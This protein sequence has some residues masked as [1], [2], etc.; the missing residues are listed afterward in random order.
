MKNL[1]KNIRDGVSFQSNISQSD[2]MIIFQKI[3]KYV[4]G[5]QNYTFSQ[6][7]CYINCTSR[8]YEKFHLFYNTEL[9]KIYYF[10]CRIT[11][12]K[13]VVKQSS[14]NEYVI[15]TLHSDFEQ[16]LLSELNGK[17]IKVEHDYNLMCNSCSK[18]FV[19]RCNTE[20]IQKLNVLP[21]ISFINPMGYAVLD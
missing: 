17:S 6:L 5:Y 13:T 21:F 7:N 1:I 2:F 20:T 15:A 16:F 10:P 9:N 18:R 19:I 14:N 3:F 11:G 12:E 8:K 4:T